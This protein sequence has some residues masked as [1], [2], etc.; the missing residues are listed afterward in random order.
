MTQT[1]RIYLDG[2]SEEKRGG[3]LDYL[4]GEVAGAGWPVEDGQDLYD[5]IWENT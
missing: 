1:M 5:L 3:P 2:V 4:V